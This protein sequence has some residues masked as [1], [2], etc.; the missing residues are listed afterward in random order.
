MESIFWSLQTLQAWKQFKETI[1]C[2]RGKANHNIMGVTQPCL[3]FLRYWHYSLSK[4]TQPD[5]N[6]GRDL[7]PKAVGKVGWTSLIFVEI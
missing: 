4:E 2:S 1:D 7:C 3:D 5:V 6:L